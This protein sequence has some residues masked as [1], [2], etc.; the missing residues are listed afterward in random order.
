MPLLE[1]KDLT[2]QFGGL[3]AVDSLSF[4]IEEGETL[5]IIGPNGAGKTTV[6]NLITGFHRPTRGDIL[7]RDVSIVGKRPHEIA[8]AGVGRTFQI[9][10]PLRGLTV[11]ENV[12]VGAYARADTDE[13]ARTVARETLEF[14]GLASLADSVAMGLPMG[15]RKRL[16]LA[17][18]LATGPC[19][20]LLD[21]VMSGLNPSESKEAVDLIKRLRDEKGIS[22]VAGVEHVMHVVMS[23][24]DRVVVL[25]HGKKIAEGRPEEVASDREVISAY[26]GH[27][28]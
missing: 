25:N 9:V 19:L 13:E 1:V 11:F 5:S 12:L 15:L 14:T 2:K 27:G 8:I 16:E 18:S 6:F 22:A 3:V 26:L 21:E 17:R 10:K 28:E 24:S 4:T 7:F 20:I 23:I